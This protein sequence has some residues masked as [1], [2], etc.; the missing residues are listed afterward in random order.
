LNDTPCYE[1]TA[2]KNSGLI[3]G[4]SN[5]RFWSDI[6][7]PEGASYK[8]LENRKM[9]CKYMEQWLKSSVVFYATLLNQ[10]DYVQSM[11]T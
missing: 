4:T 5:N 11:T 6:D 10:S 2:L 7:Y 8:S 3:I 1:T 9:H